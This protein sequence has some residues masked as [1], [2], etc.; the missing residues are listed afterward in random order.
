MASS[1]RFFGAVCIA[2]YKPLYFTKVYPD[3]VDEFAIGNA[4]ISGIVASISAFGG[5]ILS[6]KLESTSYLSKS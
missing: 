1:M 3:F 4:L 5:G 6:D 2:Y